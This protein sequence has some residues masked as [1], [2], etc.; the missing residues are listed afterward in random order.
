MKKVQY[1][2][3]IVIGLFFGAVLEVVVNLVIRKKI[4]VA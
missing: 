3:V 2:I 4:A 1:V